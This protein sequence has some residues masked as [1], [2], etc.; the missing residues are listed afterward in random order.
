[1]F[2]GGF[3]YNREYS[4][5]KT[6]ISNHGK[7]YISRTDGVNKRNQLIVLNSVSGVLIFIRTVNTD[8]DRISRFAVE[9]LVVFQNY[10]EKN[11]KLYIYCSFEMRSVRNILFVS[12]I[13][14]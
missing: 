14:N 3:M 7:L 5:E 10:F 2:N 4:V 1:M 11:K 8:P 12:R 13:Y 6:A 9:F